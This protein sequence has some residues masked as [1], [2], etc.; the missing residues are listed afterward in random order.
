LTKPYARETLSYSSKLL[1]NLREDQA[2]KPSTPKD[3][4]TEVKKYLVAREKTPYNKVL[5]FL[6][7]DDFSI[8]WTEAICEII[9]AHKIDMLNAGTAIKTWFEG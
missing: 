1:V 6:E 2:Q 8:C 3:I 9:R 4:D 7:T 5:V